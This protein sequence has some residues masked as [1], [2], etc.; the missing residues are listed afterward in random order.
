MHAW[1]CRDSTGITCGT[2]PALWEGLEGL[3][4]LQRQ[5]YREC[6]DSSCSESVSSAGFS[7]D[8]ATLL[9]TPNFVHHSNAV[10][11]IREIVMLFYP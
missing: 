11:I 1:V 6:S 2:T 10:R 3:T 5:A 9:S 8:Q 7:G 4:S